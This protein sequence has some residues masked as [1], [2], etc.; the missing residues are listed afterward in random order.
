MESRWGGEQSRHFGWR[1]RS[2][3]KG[4]GAEEGTDCSKCYAAFGVLTASEDKGG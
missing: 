4:A 3:G 1:S 2:T